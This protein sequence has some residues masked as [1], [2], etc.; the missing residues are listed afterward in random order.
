MP[1]I[2]KSK[3]TSWVHIAG[4]NRITI[5]RHPAIPSFGCQATRIKFGPMRR[6]LLV[7]EAE[8]ERRSGLRFHE[9]LLTAELE[10]RGYLDRSMMVGCGSLS[11]TQSPGPQHRENQAFPLCRPPVR[12]ITP[13]ATRSAVAWPV[14]SRFEWRPASAGAER[15]LALRGPGQ[16]HLHRQPARRSATLSDCLR[17]SLACGFD[18]LG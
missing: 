9:V 14:A 18:R 12:E 4:Q 7:T 8:P 11:E 3:R 13:M 15:A 16:L 5:G 10:K 2:Y 17:Q 1:L 6:S